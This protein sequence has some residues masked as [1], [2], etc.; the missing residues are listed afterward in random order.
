MDRHSHTE[1]TDRQGEKTIRPSLL[2]PLS[3]FSLGRRRGAKGSEGEKQIRFRDNADQFAITDDRQCP[4]TI[5]DHDDG[6][7][8]RRR[9]RPDRGGILG[10]DL[11]DEDWFEQKKQ[12]AEV[13]IMTKN[14]T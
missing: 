1:K 5:V 14:P 6:S 9:V 2:V 10:H 3:T 8:L 12:A 7:F 4:N 11:P 13:E